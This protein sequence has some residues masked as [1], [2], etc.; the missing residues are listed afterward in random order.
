MNW[1]DTL[2]VQTFEKDGPDKIILEMKYPAA[3]G[4]YEPVFEV[5]LTRK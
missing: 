1:H 3:K 4:G 5:I 2:L